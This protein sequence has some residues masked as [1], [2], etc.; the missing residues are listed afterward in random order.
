MITMQ[1]T[2]W[3]GGFSH[4][5]MRKHIGIYS[6]SFNPVHTAHIA[7]CDWLI[8]EGIVDEVW[9]IRTPH[10]PLK[11]ASGLMP[12]DL[13]QKLLDIAI[14]GHAGL[15]SCTI[16]DRLPQPNYT[17]NTLRALTREFPGVEFHLIIGADNWL[18][19]DK[20]RE[21]DIILRDY[22]VIVYPRP[23]YEIDADAQEGARAL[24]DKVAPKTAREYEHIRFVDAPIF[25]ISST[26]IRKALASGD[27]EE[28]MKMLDRRVY[29]YLIRE[30]GRNQMSLTR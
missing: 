14:E 26:A 7:L 25:D 21:Y 24:E 18:I 1:K 22:H 17:L 2:A 19:F 12:D 15:R 3:N 8:E 9:L 27:E 13:R 28:A 20:W 4:V 10:N 6:G 5:I 23:G 16:E 11:E 30:L 29:E